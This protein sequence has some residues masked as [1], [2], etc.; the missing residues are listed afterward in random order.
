MSSKTLAKARWGSNGITPLRPDGERDRR[1]RLVCITDARTLYPEK[2]TAATTHLN[3][4]SE[5]SAL[6]CLHRSS[7]LEGT[8]GLPDLPSSVLL[9]G[10]L[11]NQDWMISSTC[12]FHLIC[13]FFGT[14][15]P[16]NL[17][18]HSDSSP[19]ECLKLF[20]VWSM[21]MGSSRMQ[22]GTPPFG[23]SLDR[24]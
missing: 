11:W 9:F 1:W 21:L 15:L 18:F 19:S 24:F 3:S 16:P 5:D 4:C 17:Q 8:M 14:Q 23:A 6:D 22:M 20:G 7:A 12:N 2:H 10:A 13:W